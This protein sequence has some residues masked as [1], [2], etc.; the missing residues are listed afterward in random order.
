MQI[1]DKMLD[2]TKLTV[3]Q[4]T[5]SEINSDRAIDSRKSNKPM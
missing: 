2:A 4:F 5:E 1:L 3:E